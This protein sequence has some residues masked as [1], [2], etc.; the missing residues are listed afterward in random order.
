MNF[1][2]S[3]GMNGSQNNYAKLKKVNERVHAEWNHLYKILENANWSIVP[4]TKQGLP[5]DR[6]WWIGLSSWLCIPVSNCTFE[7]CFVGY[8]SV[9]YSWIKLLK[10]QIVKSRSYRKKG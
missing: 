5:G 1:D 3:E 9:N 4:K 10:V 6:D 8:T 2:E 7:K